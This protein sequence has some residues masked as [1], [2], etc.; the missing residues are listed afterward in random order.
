MRS[1]RR[2]GGADPRRRLRWRHWP[3]CSG[4]APG[5]SSARPGRKPDRQARSPAQRGAGRAAAARRMGGAWRRTIGNSGACA[6]V[7]FLKQSDALVYTGGSAIRDDVKGAG[8]FVFSPALLAGRAAGRGQSRFRAEPSLSAADG[9][10][11]N[12]RRGSLSGS[13]VLVRRRP[14]CRRRNLDG[15]RSGADGEG[16][17]LGRGGAVLHRAGGAGA[18]RRPA[19]SGTVEGQLRNDHLQYAITWYGLAAVLVAMFAI[20][21]VRRRRPE[22]PKYSHEIMIYAF[23]VK[24]G[25][26]A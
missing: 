10:Q 5:R 3:S 24:P 21:V 1:R 16:Q 12:R 4:S 11:R 7:Q 17:R 6:A 18:A 20:W 23:L 8:Y 13:A 19:A 15:A 26:S 2:R 9:A 14:R 25:A 22:K